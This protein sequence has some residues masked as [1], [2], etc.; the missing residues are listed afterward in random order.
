MYNDNAQKLIDNG[1]HPIPIAPPNADPEVLPKKCPVRFVP[2]LGKHVKFKDWSNR[3]EPI[4]TPQADAGIGVRCGDNG[5][6]AFDYDAEDAALVI[7]EAFACPVNKAGERGWTAFFRA[8]FAVS[9]EDFHDKDGVLALQVLSSGKQTVI[10]PS[11]HPDT[12][13]SYRWTNGKTL[14]DTKVD[15]LPPLPR[16]YR[17]RILAL[18]YL[19]SNPKK[20][21]VTPDTVS[22][23]DADSTLAELNAL[24][25]KNLAQWVPALGLYN[26]K[27]RM[28]R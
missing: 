13:Q 5:L 7:S 22:T 28:G 21:R 27:R 14:Y 1:Y 12:K 4:M 15:E 18:G 11:I 6:V 20:D 23:V 17:E 24:A 25:L 9:S 2:E 8:D 10:P 19:A 16:D 26:C 3:P